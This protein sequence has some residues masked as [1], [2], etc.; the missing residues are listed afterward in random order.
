[1]RSPV[2]GTIPAGPILLDASKSSPLLTVAPSSSPG[3]RS[4]QEPGYWPASVDG[5]PLHF[6]ARKLGGAVVRAMRKAD[7]FQQL[8]RAKDAV[9][10]RDAGF[11]L[12]ELDVL[13]GREHGKK[14]ESLKDKTYFG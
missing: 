3:A 11:G 12:R 13:P 7:I 2:V 14:K 6:P 4:Q 1:M 5:D 10:T 8:R 9:L